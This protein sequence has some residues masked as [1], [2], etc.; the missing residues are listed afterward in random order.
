VVASGPSQRF[1]KFSGVRDLGVGQ[2]PAQGFLYFDRDM[3]AV[4]PAASLAKKKCRDVGRDVC[5]C[6]V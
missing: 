5:D 6:P 1:L 4:T 3:G 2:I